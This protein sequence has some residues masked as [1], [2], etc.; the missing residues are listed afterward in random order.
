LF[1]VKCSEENPVEGENCLCGRSAR[2]AKFSTYEDRKLGE[3][4]QKASSANREKICVFVNLRENT[5]SSSKCVAELRKKAEQ[6]ESAKDTFN[7]KPAQPTKRN[8][9]NQAISGYFFN[10]SCFF[11]PFP[12]FTSCFAGAELVRPPRIS[13]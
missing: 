7:H 10:L 12:D 2:A 13:R 9:R 5:F 1:R 3:H 8:Q 4:E 11:V 6:Q